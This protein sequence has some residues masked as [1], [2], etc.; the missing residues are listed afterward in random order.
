MD[1]KIKNKTYNSAD[2]K[3][4][5]EAE[6]TAIGHHHDWSIDFA[7]CPLRRI[8]SLGDCDSTGRWKRAHRGGHQ[9][10]RKVG[11]EGKI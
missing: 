5:T 1:T 6:R 7:T 8:L 4:L 10:T 9:V 3:A 2:Y 11:T